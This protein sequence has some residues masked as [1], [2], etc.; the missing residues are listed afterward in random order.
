MDQRAGRRNGRGFAAIAG[1]AVLSLASL[2]PL[3]SAS[4]AE[5]VPINQTCQQA[6][7]LV[8][9]NLFGD[10]TCGVTF[11]CPTNTTS[12]FVGG[13]IRVDGVGLHSATMDVAADSGFAS[14]Y[15]NGVIP[16]PLFIESYSPEFTSIDPGQTA[17][18]T[19]TATGLVS[20]NTTLTCS[21]V[22]EYFAT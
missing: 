3:S 13:Y 15:T 16:A 14:H 1:L 22:G 12:C 20:V 7:S 19:C 4:A 2:L 21:L 9:G 18:A 17:S 10:A 8:V 6:K 11:T 5:R